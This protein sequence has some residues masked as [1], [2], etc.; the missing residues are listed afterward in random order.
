MTA[1]LLEVRD[2]AVEFAVE[3]AWRPVVSDLSFD[4]HQGEV[5]GI[6]GESGSGKTVTSRA[7]ISLLPAGVSRVAK[8]QVLF[9]GQDLL[10]L[11]P[12]AL[13]EV[14]G[15]RIGMVFQNPTTHLDPV[16]RIGEQ[17][18]IGLRLHR[19]MDRAQARRR[20]IAL[21][22]EVGFSDP[23]RQ[24]DAFPHEL[25]GG[26]RQRAMIA[27]AL[28]CDPAVLIADEPTTALDV[29]V[30]AQII[31]LLRDLQTSRSLSIIFISHDLGLV[32]DFCDGVL[33]MERGK[34]VEAGEVAGILDR[35]QHPYTRKLLGAQPGLTPPGHFFPI[36]GEGARGG[37]AVVDPDPGAMAL[38]VSDLEVLFPG[39]RNIA[40]VLRRKPAEAFAAVEGV[41][42]TLRRG[43][44]LGLVGESGSGKSTLARAVVGLVRPSG[45]EIRL[46]GARLDPEAQRHGQDWRRKVQMIF[47]DPL[48][49]LNPKMTVAETLA[50]PLRV[51]RICAREE[52][53][54][55]VLRLLHEVGMD[56]E[57][58]TRKPHQ[59]SGGQ[60]QRVG[61]ARAL[62]MEPEL[63]LADEPTSAL[64]VTIQA[65]ILN[66]LLHLRQSRG[67]TMLFISHD[68]AVVRHLCQRIAVMKRGHL[69]E[70]G[71][72]ED[73]YERP[74]HAYT[75]SLLSAV[76]EVAKAS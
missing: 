68:L 7:L 36:E 14:R 8:G 76:P 65:Q 41:S 72:V 53:P 70:T 56:A 66:L 44:A 47:Q 74:Q 75:Q 20:T 28:S 61:I 57:L 39:K 73:I 69:V 19:D 42:L 6:V 48:T 49:S 1:P 11:S 34:V 13:A 45:G 33:V 32:A 52:I 30:Q 16:M 37:T 26:M 15:G 54:A 60:C 64:D 12:T 29:T 18:A 35:P 10:H 5:L 67:L 38:E 21:L 43:E 23:A 4:L 63:L 27:A 58:A 31:A 24:V 25:S 71:A 3:E 2:L 9:E 46:D 59:L 51:H 40:D 17:I 50:E 62:A 55:R 22:D